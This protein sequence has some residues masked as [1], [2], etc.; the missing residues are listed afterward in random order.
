M[1]NEID[2]LSWKASGEANE[3]SLMRDGNW[4]AMIRMNGEMLV[5]NQERVIRHIVACANASLGLNT[6]LLENIAITG[7][8]VERFALLNQTER[9][10]DEL[11]AAARNLRHMKGRH[12]TEQAYNMLMEVVDKVESGQ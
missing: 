8:L 5:P 7:G 2:K 9:Q 10:R 1:S 11:L 4:M 12:H 6:E 3:Y